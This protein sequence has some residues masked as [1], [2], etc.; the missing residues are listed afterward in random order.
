VHVVRE[1]AKSAWRWCP[2]SESESKFPCGAVGWYDDDDVVI[3]FESEY[4][5][6]MSRLCRRK[7]RV[8]YLRSKVCSRLC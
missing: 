1:G 5:K 3:Y 6:D 2:I 4:L 7:G 8:L